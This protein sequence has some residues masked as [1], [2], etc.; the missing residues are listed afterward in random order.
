MDLSK[1]R[2]T[3]ENGGV[4]TDSPPQNSPQLSPE[5]IK[6]ILE[7][8]TKEQLL[9]IV[10]SSITRDPLTLSAVRTIADNDPAQRKLFIRGL[11]WETTTDKLQSIFSTFGEVAEAIVITD[12]NSGK[13]KGYGFVTFK[14]IDGAMVALRE[15][16]KK[17][18]GRVTVTQLAANGVSGG[19]VG[20]GVDVSMRK[21][22]VGNIPFEISSE[23]LLGVFEGFGEIEEGPL[24]FD[25]QSGK[26]KGFAFFVYK[27]EEGARSSLVEPMKMIDGF[28]VNCK[29]ATDGK[30]GRGGENVGQG[31]PG[32]GNP[33]YGYQGQGQFGGTGQFGGGF[34]GMGMQGG[35][36][37]GP[38]V[39]SG[40]GFGNQGPGQGVY[41]GPGGGGYGGNGQQFASGMMQP[42][43][44]GGGSN[45]GPGSVYR[46]PPNSAGVPPIGGYQDGGSYGLPSTGFGQPQLP[47]QSGPRG[48]P[49]GMYQG[50][51]PHYY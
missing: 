7:P 5:D 11:G 8:F 1:K 42:G 50:V 44:Y 24:G 19:G 18:D 47:Q 38:M 31:Q 30:K 34:G 41:S 15:P 33:G 48:P 20:G 22:Y 51:P 26:A 21:I 25:K 23:R 29:Y 45:M 2:K 3:D 27:T 35:G 10:Q 17:I 16:N 28:Q 40:S 14:H 12:K 49:G 37:Q 32:G 36:H 4:F 9:E 13:S 43:E 46:M 6:K 39:N